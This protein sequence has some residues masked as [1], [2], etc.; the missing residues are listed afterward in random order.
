VRVRVE[1]IL[2]AGQDDQLVHQLVRFGGFDALLVCADHK[3]VSS[4]D[5][6]PAV[7]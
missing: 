4:A 1:N 6:A 7:E 2:I 5:D 3:G